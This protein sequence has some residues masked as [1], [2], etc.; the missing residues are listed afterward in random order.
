MVE[1]VRGVD[2][3]IDA[4]MKVRTGNLNYRGST[5]LKPHT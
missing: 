1:A 2:S 3:R 4:V 5:P